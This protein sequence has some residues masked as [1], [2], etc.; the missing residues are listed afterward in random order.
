MV[1]RDNTS[2]V[3]S[4]V[5][6]S[7]LLGLIAAGV[8]VG[9]FDTNL[10]QHIIPISYSHYTSFDN[11]WINDYF[12]SFFCGIIMF[13]YL[14]LLAS[15]DKYMKD[16][17]SHLEDSMRFFLVLCSLPLLYFIIPYIKMAL[18]VIFIIDHL[19]INLMYELSH[20]YVFDLVVLSITSYF[21]L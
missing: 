12:W 1:E 21:I 4:I 13:I 20:A 15:L 18:W 9:I 17:E 19:I 6:P 3:P 16:D 14:P 8:S 11:H 7:V 10:F 5:I 2:P